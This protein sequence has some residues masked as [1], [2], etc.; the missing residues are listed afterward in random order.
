MKIYICD[1]F[2]SIYKLK[3]AQLQVCLAAH[4]YLAVQT[5]DEADL[6]ISGV[7]AAFE[8]DEARSVRIMEINGHRRIPHYVIGCLVGV[9]P[10]KVTGDHLYHTWEFAKLARD[11]TGVDIAGYDNAYLP[12]QFRSPEDYRV[13]DPLRR[14]VGITTGCGF[15]C[16]YCPHK[17]GA[18]AVVSRP[19]DHILREV[20]QC[21]AEGAHIIHLTGLDTASYGQEIDSSFGRLLT[22][23]LDRI[24]DD[25]H[26]HIAQFNPEGILDPD[27]FARLR[28]ACCD[29][30]VADFQIPVQTASP[31][32]LRMMH[33]HY[34]VDAIASFIAEIRRRNPRL[35]FRT[36]VMVGFPSE[37]LDE[38]EETVDCVAR[39]FNEAAVY[40]FERKEGTPIAQLHALADE[41]SPQEKQRRVEHV[42]QRLLSAGLLVHSGA[43]RIHSLLQADRA[44]ALHRRQPR[45]SAGLP[46]PTHPQ[47]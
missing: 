16:S 42:T 41:F 37:H 6:T 21:L 44:K 11:L 8:A 29:P 12:S 35:F 26:F 10:A 32:L 14:F 31:R 45:P 23:I 22:L 27:E 3:M 28:E 7:C 5:P 36:D 20:R 25:V 30:R 4:G 19:A 1:N 17:L 15:D 33:R 34:E 40:S 24:Q 38:L 43:Q 47:S 2:C 46:C 13:Y 9:N 18:G 39:S